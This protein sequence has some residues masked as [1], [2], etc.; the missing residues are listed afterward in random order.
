MARYTLL[1]IIVQHPD[2]PRGLIYTYNLTR[3]VD[4]ETNVTGL[5]IENTIPKPPGGESAN[6]QDG[7]ML[8][9]DA[10]FLLYGGNMKRIEGLVEPPDGD[11]ILGYQ[12]YRYGAER[13]W[14]SQ[15]DEVTLSN[16]THRY[17]AYGGAASAPSENKAWYF[18]GMTSPSVGELES[19]VVPD[20]SM[21]AQNISNY[22]IEVDMAVQ[23]SEVWTNT[24]LPETVQ[25]R[26]NP[27]V[28]WVPVGEQGILVV[29][30]GV[31]YPHWAGKGQESDDRDA[32][33]SS[34]L[35]TT[36]NK[37]AR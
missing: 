19:I 27:E 31:T 5:L 22:L 2:D 10:E 9:N 25:G 3:P 7:A 24:S 28:V 23:S 36:S 37:P 30:G 8:A 16:R 12:I 11:E 33:V 20:R 29:L 4:R 26:A 17:I 34:F 6:F 13:S 1:T 35:L 14:V 21:T 32:S 15:F 18:S